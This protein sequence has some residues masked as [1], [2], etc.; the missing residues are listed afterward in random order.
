MQTYHLWGNLSDP[1]LLGS[2]QVA[3]KFM[4]VTE[5]PS[6]GSSTFTVGKSTVVDQRN[7]SE[8]GH[9]TSSLKQM[10]INFCGGR[11]YSSGGVNGIELGYL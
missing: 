9:G 2:C 1:F 11:S 4:H 10:K 3:T 5:F 8:K 6:S 7:M